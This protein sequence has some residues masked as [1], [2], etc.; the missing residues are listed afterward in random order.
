[1]MKQDRK[2]PF[3]LGVNHHLLFPASFQ[4]TSVHM[5]TLPIVLGMPA[6][7]LVD[8]FI[9]NDDI[10]EVEEPMIVASGKEPIYN[11]P[12]MVGATLNPHSPDSAIRM[13]TRQ[14]AFAHID[15]AKRIGARKMV[16]ASGVDPGVAE[17]GRETKLFIDYMTELCEYA[18]PDL[19]LMIEPFDRSIGKNLLMGPTHEVVAVVETVKARGFENVGILM[20]MGHVPLMEE[21]FA[22][23]VATA[24]PHIRHVHL[25]SCVMRDPSDPLYGDMHPP[26]GYPGGENDVAEAVEFLRCLRDIGYFDGTEPATVTLEMR[27]YSDKIETDSVAIFLRKLDEALLG[28]EGLER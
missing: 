10:G 1:M 11:C 9:P 28:L 20:D 14:E 2:L 18:G 4:S 15:R 16:V 5:D 27:P 25:G 26:W 3:Q 12:L 23:A 13:A 22:H 8:C 19:C 24:G 21:S 17:R 7:E 6:F